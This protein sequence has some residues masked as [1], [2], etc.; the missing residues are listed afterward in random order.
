MTSPLEQLQALTLER[1]DPALQHCLNAHP[2]AE[3]LLRA[4]EYSVLNGGKR[5]RP[6]LAYGAALA[7]ADINTD[8]D[9][10]ACAVELIHAYSLIHD[11]LPAMDDDDLRRGN[12]TCHVRF[13]EASA[14]LAGDA[15][16]ALAFEQFTQ[17]THTP[18]EKALQMSAVLAQAAGARGMVAGQAIDLAA[19]DQS[20]SLQ[21]LEQM[22]HLKTGALINASTQLGAISAGAST[23]Q[24]QALGKYSHCI[25]LAFQVQ[26]DILD[27][28]SSTDTLGKRQGADQ[29]LNKPTYT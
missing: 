19:V 11:D 25:G 5:V 20:L 21:Q 2:N 16:Q 22:H 18:A 6:M 4:M 10:A 15:L 1:V 9:R 26:D 8:T 12:P 23:G 3:S 27:V 14:I 24:L 17:L 7:V 13:G 29:A 28:E